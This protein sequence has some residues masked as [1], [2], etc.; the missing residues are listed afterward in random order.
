LP[1]IGV[2]TFLPPEGVT[3]PDTLELRRATEEEKQEQIRRLRDFKA[4]HAGDRDEALARLQ[5]AAVEGGN[6]FDAL[7][8]AVR[9]CTLGEITNALYEVGGR[10]RR[11]M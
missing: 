8:H 6:T 9:H 7:M 2:N 5:A 1:I 11:S 4:R 3:V 10:Y